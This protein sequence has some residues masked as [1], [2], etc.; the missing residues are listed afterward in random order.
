MLNITDNEIDNEH[1][2]NKQSAYQSVLE[3][4]A[5]KKILIILSVLF[6][7]GFLILF[8]PWRQNIT[9]NGMLT[10][11]QPEDR[12]QTI[13]SMISGRVE[14]WYVREGQE[15]KTG[16]TIVF[17]SEIKPI[18][19]D[20][21][22]VERAKEQTRAKQ[23]AAGAYQNKARALANQINALEQSQKLKL[24]QAN[25]KIL[26]SKFKVTSDSIDYETALINL[27]IAHRQFHRQEK[28][29]NQGLKSL[30]ELEKRKQKLQETINK[31]ISA[32]NKWE[33]SKNELQN[34]MLARDNLTNEFTEGDVRPGTVCDLCDF[35][36]FVDL[37]GI[38]G[39]I[40]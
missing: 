28:L 13:H 16:D 23:D 31:K 20:P 24:R 7:F 4:K 34:N 29:Y 8:F 17:I 14:K 25:N 1:I 40:H 5:S 15:V 30:T 6:I 18:Y 2:L 27:D 33:A 35:G 22:L 19:L 37:G 26:Q 12:E 39:L 38:D 11:L 3:N 9:A 10:T 21:Q 36:A 32:Q